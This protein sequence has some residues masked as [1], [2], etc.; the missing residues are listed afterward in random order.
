M[1]AEDLATHGLSA[2]IGG[3]LALLIQSGTNYLREKLKAKEDSVQVALLRTIADNQQSTNETL[4]QL[5]QTMGE[6][7]GKLSNVRVKS[8][9]AGSD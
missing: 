3:V 8:N 6:L 9:A 5:S 4:V 7:V 1:M 2:G